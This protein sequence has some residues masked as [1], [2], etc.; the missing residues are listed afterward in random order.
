MDATDY[1]DPHVMS[2]LADMVNRRMPHMPPGLLELSILRGLDLDGS[3]L[4]DIQREVAY[5]YWPEYNGYRPARVNETNG[6][7][8]N[9]LY[10]PRR[11]D[12]GREIKLTPQPQCAEPVGPVLPQVEGRDKKTRAKA[13][14][15]RL[16]KQRRKEKEKKL[17]DKLN[18]EKQKPKMKAEENEG[19]TE[20]MS[21]DVA[22]AAAVGNCS[23]GA[24]GQSSSCDSDS[25]GC[26]DDSDEAAESQSDSERKLD[27]KEPKNT[28][29]DRKKE[30]EEE[31]ERRKKKAPVKQQQ[32]NPVKNKPAREPPGGAAKAPARK[33]VSSTIS[34]A[35]ISIKPTYEDNVK[36]STELSTVGNQYASAG[37]YAIAVQYFTD[38]I[39]YNPKEFR[40]VELLHKRPQMF[41]TVTHDSNKRLF[42]NRS[43]CFERLQQYEKALNDAQLSLNMAPGWVKGLYRKGRALAGLKEC[44]F[45]R[46]QSSSALIIHGTVGKAM[47]VLSKLNRPNHTGIVY[48]TPMLPPA[49]G[50]YPPRAPAPVSPGLPRVLPSA[51]QPP[52]SSPNNKPLTHNTSNM[53]A[54]AVPGAGHVVKSYVLP[55]AL[56]LRAQLS[57]SSPSSNPLKQS[58]SNMVAKA[59]PDPVKSSKEHRNPPPVGKIHSVKFL[60]GRRCAF[61]NFTTPVHCN[62]AIMKFHGYA[63][64]GTKL[65]LRG[66][67]STLKPTPQTPPPPGSRAG[68]LQRQT[69]LTAS[70][71]ELLSAGERYSLPL[72]QTHT[73]YVACPG[74]GPAGDAPATAGAGTYTPSGRLAKRTVAA[75]KMI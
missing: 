64:M 59:S 70:H 50:E 21:G 12:N 16:K 29:P 48:K 10:Q 55:S 43:F 1:M 20:T 26:S 53:V 8:Q 18:K 13:A 7:T 34:A 56:Q 32:A 3:F 49:M 36:I 2:A 17:L 74:P 41:S 31:E 25:S 23:G 71:V 58:T 35:P 39:K 15:K 52:P 22:T 19:A 65:A 27:L 11:Y 60:S 14:K 45:T 9:S 57:P 42:G 61:V 54:K 62:Q 5:R 51:L 4:G 6:S 68:Q 30:E 47:E 67:P 46:E 40:Q 66:R 72:G 73:S 33:D 75:S 69:L 38:A 37:H 44:G 28:K 63:L 24:D